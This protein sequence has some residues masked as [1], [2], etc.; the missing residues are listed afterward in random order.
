MATNNGKC[1]GED[2][3]I[4]PLLTANAMMCMRGSPAVMG[5]W[6]RFLVAA[7]P[8]T[9]LTELNDWGS[10]F[11]GYQYENRYRHNEF[12]QYV[13][14][15][16]FGLQDDQMAGY[17]LQQPDFIP[18]KLDAVGSAPEC[19]PLHIPNKNALVE[20]IRRFQKQYPEVIGCS[21]H[22]AHLQ[23]GSF[24]IEVVYEFSDR[25]KLVRQARLNREEEIEFK[26]KDIGALLRELKGKPVAQS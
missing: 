16:Q 22:S 26:D 12:M 25:Q 4:F 18:A 3:K 15:Y 11:L 17:L 13:H 1:I 19:S 10:S 14:L 7:L 5:D 8:I 20:V 24:R 21:V 2:T 23:K 6:L 9:S